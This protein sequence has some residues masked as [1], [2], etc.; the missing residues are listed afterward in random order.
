MVGPEMKQTEEGTTTRVELSM[1][2]SQ[3]LTEKVLV[4]AAAVAKRLQKKLK[5]SEEALQAVVNEKAWLQEER[6]DTAEEKD[7]FFI[8]PFTQMYHAASPAQGAVGTGDLILSNQATWV[9]LRLRWK[10]PCISWRGCVRDPG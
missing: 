9:S 6:W 4:Y 7:C 8:L 10:I 3:T 2:G 1:V 5:A